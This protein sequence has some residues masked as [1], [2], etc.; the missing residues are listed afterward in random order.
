MQAQPDFF[1]S[2]GECGQHL[3]CL[4]LGHAMHHRVVSVTLEFH[5]GELPFQP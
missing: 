1:H 4:P 5:G 2:L 3:T